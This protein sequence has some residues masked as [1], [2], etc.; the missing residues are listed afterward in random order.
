MRLFNK[1]A[2]LLVLTSCS[3]MGGGESDNYHWQS[4]SDGK[5]EDERTEQER[6]ERDL[7]QCVAQAHGFN[8]ETDQ[9]MQG[10]GYEKHFD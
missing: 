8:V 9:C 10:R 1:V 7:S 2:A 4:A 3:W 5:H 6:T